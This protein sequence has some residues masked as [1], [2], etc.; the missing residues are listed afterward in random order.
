M[1]GWNWRSVWVR[2]RGQ[3]RGVKTYLNC[4]LAMVWWA[5]I[6]VRVDRAGRDGDVSVKEEDLCRVWSVK[7]ELF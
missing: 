4:I 3:A 7:S 2:G 6:K 5:Y 1:V